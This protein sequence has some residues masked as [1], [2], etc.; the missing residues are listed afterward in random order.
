[1]KHF[2]QIRD[3]AFS[4][5]QRL[6]SEEFDVQLTEE[7]IVLDM[8][9]FSREDIIDYL[10]ENNVE[11]EEKDEVIYILDRV[12]QADITIENDNEEDVEESLDIEG[13]DLNEVTARRKIVVRKGRRKIIFKCAPG[14]M[15]KGLRSCVRR[16]SSSLRKLKFRA[17]RTARKSRSKRNQARRKRKIS[18]RKRMSFGLRPRKKK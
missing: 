2:K 12:E 6:F 13:E 14:M 3:H 9:N 10:D 18:M 5:L 17:K 1:M 16:P 8:P 4:C 15:K 11:W 7:K